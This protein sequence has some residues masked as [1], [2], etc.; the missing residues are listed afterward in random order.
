MASNYGKLTQGSILN[1]IKVKEF[2]DVK[3]FGVVITA[4]CDI[5]NHKINKYYYLLAAPVDIWI[6]TEGLKLACSKYR[7]S[8][9]KDWENKVPEY[10]NFENYSLNELIDIIDKAKFGD[11]EK[12]KIEAIKEQS[13][14]QL[15]ELAALSNGKFNT[16]NVNNLLKIDTIRARLKDSLKEIFSGKHTHYWFIPLTSYKNIKTQNK[17]EQYEGLIVNLLE[18]DFFDCKI[19]SMIEKQEMDYGKLK[20]DQKELI[21]YSEKFYLEQLEDIIYPE[22]EIKSPYIEL[23]MQKFS[24]AFIRIG[25][26]TPDNNELLNFWKKKI[27]DLKGE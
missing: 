1:N 13:L 16:E 22:H 12:Q 27:D 24:E 23:L 26:D 21:K 14:R 18:I 20:D 17:E 6:R 15:K 8:I 25:V 11:E 5:A 3:F 10:E 2:P 9:L 19:A 7:K 4:R